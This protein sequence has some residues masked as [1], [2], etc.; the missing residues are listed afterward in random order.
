MISVVDFN[1]NNITVYSY[2]KK[3]EKC[4]IRLVGC[5]E[6]ENERY[7]KDFVHKIYRRKKADKIAFRL[8][9]GADKFHSPQKVDRIFLHEMESSNYINIECRKQ[10]Y[11]LE[12]KK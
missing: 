6:M 8:L 4:S 5:G 9:F 10:P 1:Y 2:E 3:G 12:I 7:L 11:W